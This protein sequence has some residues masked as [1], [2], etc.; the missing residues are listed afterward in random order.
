MP[1][2]P[3]YSNT[4]GAEP[5]GDRQRDETGGLKVTAPPRAEPHSFPGGWLLSVARLVKLWLA[6]KTLLLMAFGWYEAGGHGARDVERLLYAFFAIG[7]LLWSGLYLLNEWCDLEDDRRRANK[8][9]RPLAAGFVSPGVG[10]GLA[11]ALIGGGM[12]M[13]CR[14]AWG[15]GALAGLMA[16]SQVLY[17]VPPARLKHRAIF[18]VLTVAVANPLLRFS[19]GYFC[20]ANSVAVPLGAVAVLIGGHL[21]GALLLRLVSRETDASYGHQTTCTALPSAWVK[22]G[23]VAAAVLCI[24]AIVALSLA[25][26]LGLP[27][28]FGSVP[29]QT[30]FVLVPLIGFVPG[31]LRLA[32]S[33]ESHNSRR[34]RAVFWSMLGVLGVA[35]FFVLLAYPR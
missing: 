10:L 35:E 18:D 4:T 32:R 14:L 6:P 8:R 16:L 17:C 33:P 15:L 5:E 12:V 20:V 2:E 13:S 25:G 3:W 11:V 1:A 19:A 30:L 24:S 21:A 26:D 23:A 27:A 31:F 29:R 34:V 7:I 22:R 28:S 9:D